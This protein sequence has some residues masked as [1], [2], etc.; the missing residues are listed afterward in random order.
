[1]LSG[2]KNLY[3]TATTGPPPETVLMIHLGDLI[4]K[5]NGPS[6]KIL[7][8]RREGKKPAE[9]RPWFFLGGV[10]TAESKDTMQNM[11]ITH[12]LNVADNVR[13]FFPHDFAYLHIQIVDGGKDGGIVDAFK[14]AREF[15]EKAKNAGGKVLIHCLHGVNR[16][17]TTAMAVLMQMEGLTLADAF[18][19]VKTQRAQVAVMK[20]N[21]AKIAAWERTQTGQCTRPDWLD[22]DQ[23]M[24]EALQD[25]I[26]RVEQSSARGRAVDPAGGSAVDPFTLSYF[27]LKKW[28][29]AEELLPPDVLRGCLAPAAM[30]RAIHTAGYAMSE[31]QMTKLCEMEAADGSLRMDRSNKLNQAWE[32]IK[33]SQVFQK[34]E[35]LPQEAS[36]Q[37]GMVRFVVISDTHGTHEQMGELPE[38]DVLLHC[39]DFTKAG[40]PDEVASFNRW[41]G[42]QPHP[43]KLLIC[44]NHEVSL[45]KQSHGASSA[46]L[47]SAQYL[48]D[49]AVEVTGGLLVYGTPWCPDSGRYPSAFMLPRGESMQGVWQQIPAG[50]DVLMSH[51]PP[52]GRGD[53]TGTGV[54]AG[55]QDLLRE[56]QERVKPQLAVFGHVHSQGGC[57][58]SDGITTFANCAI[59]DEVTHQAKNLPF[60]FD[61]P[62][63]R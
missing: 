39:G 42:L 52:L 33:A 21:M 37:P 24:Q 26:W 5:G 6:A 25:D 40:K 8:S 46:A 17:A 18:Q 35:S 61:L 3:L 13:C 15:V 51:G 44:G 56:I 38:G 23:S 49:E 54:H 4:G 7:R 22:C 19:H 59:V 1:V 16:S 45:E 36:R 9:L 29:A 47:S 60:V 14:P 34:A 32:A 30:L 28:I 55:C 53:C 11:G 27:Q 31:A 62:A 2:L 43:V 41:L 10:K 20:G 58:S 48:Q 12:I 63:K 57:I 50:V